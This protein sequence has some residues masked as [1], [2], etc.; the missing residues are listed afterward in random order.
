MIHLVEFFTHRFGAMGNIA[1]VVVFLALV[2]LGLVIAMR[3]RAVMVGVV[4]V[5]GFICGVLAGAMIG[6]LCFNSIILMVILASVGG[7]LLLYTV[8]NIKSVGYF[9]GI[10]S[11]T[12]FLTFTL[13]SQMYVTD[14]AVTE[15]TL[16][17]IDLAAAVVMGILAACRSKYIVSVITAISGGVITAISSLAILGYY[18]ADLKTWIIAG[19]VAAAGIMVQINVY[20]L[21]GSSKK[22]GKLKK[23][24]RK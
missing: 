16:L 2:V 1:S 11:L 8:K 7:V 3:G 6:L 12:W 17:F 14:E 22:G 21:K 19:V 24:K 9:I 13:T 15:N 5:C 18:F 20:D 4:A 10:G 23:K